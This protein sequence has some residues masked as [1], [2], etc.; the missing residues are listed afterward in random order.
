MKSSIKYIL[1]LVI[2]FLIG[3]VVYFKVFVPK[4]TFRVVHPT[5][6]S[7]QEVV[8]GIGNVNGLN[9]YTITAQ[10][11]G[12]ILQILTDEGEKV[13]KG[14][15]LVVMDGVDLP[16][17]LIVARAN[18]KKAKYEK[19]ALQG[20]LANQEAQRK[21]LQLTFDRYKKLNRQGFVARAEYDKA[22]SDLQAIEATISATVARIDSAVAA[23]QAARGNVAQLQQKID[24]LRVYA[25]T[26]G[27]VIARDAEAAQYVQPSTPVLKIVDPQTLWVE[28]KVD[29]RLCALVRKGLQ[30][31][32]VL[33]SQP[34]TMYHGVVK[35]IDAM[36]DD[37]TLERTINIAFTHIPEPFFINEQARVTIVVRQLDQVLKIPRTVLVQ[38]GGKDGVWVDRNGRAHFLPITTIGENNSEVALADDQK[39]LAVIVPDSHKKSLR[40]GMRI[41]Q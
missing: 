20:E 32:V 39:G 11:G 14:D 21:L 38:R 3:G 24:R 1:L 22:L 6:G 30:A 28:T 4:H 35:R 27:L 5:K 36:S 23:V 26:D 33:R 18:L 9:I 2:L 8:R 40:E 13:H 37:V 12:K 16:Q 7:L 34:E 31:T 19:K 10:T 17:Q 29:E 41:F 25:P 15:L